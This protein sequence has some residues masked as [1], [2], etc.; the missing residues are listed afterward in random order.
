MRNPIIDIGAKELTYEIREIVDIANKVKEFGKEIIWENIG[1]PIAKGEKLPDWIK[2]IIVEEVRNDSSYGYCPTKGLYET[3]E[4]LAEQ[5]NKRGKTQITAEDIIFF[6]GL[7]DAI[8]K[9]YGLL[10]REIRVIN[11]SPSYSTHSSAEASHAGAPPITYFLDPC[12]CWY[13][14]MDD[15]YNRIKYNPAVSGIL[16]INPDNP[17]GA[18]YSKK[19]L[20]EIVDIANEFDLFIICDEIYCNLIYNN[21][22]KVLLSDVIDDVPGISLKGISKEL[23]WPGGRCGWIEVYNYNKDEEFKRYINSIYKA[24]LI[25]V[26][27]TTLPQKVI[28]KIFGDKRY[29]KYLKERNKFYEKRSNDAY[30][31]LKNLDG[32]IVNR[33]NGAFYMSIVFENGVNGEIK[34]TNPNLKEFVEKLYKGKSL[35]RKFC[36]QLLA[37]TGICVVPLT[38]FCTE[39]NGFRI[40]LLEKDDKKFNFIFD[41]IREKIEEFINNW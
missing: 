27:S 24:K 37:E 5:T 10:R 26:C 30:N 16:I 34:I 2:E 14:D 8:A 11:P 36:Y 33:A 12:Q 15:L 4:F 7:G 9:I 40:T 25:E 32:V 38:S 28:P 20:D 21:K 6:N 23:P 19:V 39:L 31:K 1:D 22:K 13:P 18:V 29:S 17:T 35:D 41:T 3:R